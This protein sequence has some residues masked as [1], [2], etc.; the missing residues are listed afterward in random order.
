MRKYKDLVLEAYSFAASVVATPKSTRM[1]NL[2]DE[3]RAL[4]HIPRSTGAEDALCQRLCYAKRKRQ[5]SE[6]Q[7]VELA[8]LSGSRSREPVLRAAS[9]ASAER[10]LAQRPE[11]MNTLMAQIR[12]LGH[13]PRGNNSLSH[14]LRYAKRKRQLSES[15]LAE[16]AEI[17]RCSVEP[18]RKRL[19]KLD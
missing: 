13:I 14:R 11:R 7:L 4:G 12:A 9:S 8:Q 17:A 6:S 19:R 16:L 15:Q 10:K 5:L 1:E 3:I 2:M 18:V